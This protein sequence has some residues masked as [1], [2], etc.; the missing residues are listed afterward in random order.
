MKI[1]IIITYF[2]ERPAWMDYLLQ[3][4]ASN[5]SIEWLFYTDIKVPEECP[6][7]IRFEN[8]TMDDFNRL[9]SR[10]LD[11]SID[12]R[13]PYKICDLRPAFGHIFSEYLEDYNIWGYADLDL[14][15]GDISAFLTKDLLENHDVIS[16]REG[17]L[18][19]H[20]ALYRNTS[21]IKGLYTKSSK[22]RQIFQD[23]HHHYAFDERSNI[24]GQKICDRSG[25]VGNWRI[26]QKLLSL[27][28]KLR[29]RMDPALKEMEYCDMSSIVKSLSA[30]GEIRFYQQDL[31]RSDLW[32][33]KHG[34]RQWEIAWKDGTLLDIGT[35]EKFLHFHFI[36]SKENSRFHIEPSQTGKEFRIKPTGI[37]PVG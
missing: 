28:R 20:F 27:V 3:T 24:I 11:L 31:V 30:S 33:K 22:Y 32:Y 16:S 1:L 7:N 37:K 13:H 15:F 14:V 26:Y 19:G 5:A 29:L 17:Y 35:G 36:R 23:A 8:K 4:C 10:N 34:I 9:A 6:D 21:A 18:T 25:M 2:G 12:I